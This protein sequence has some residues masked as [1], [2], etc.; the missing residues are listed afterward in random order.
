MAFEDIVVVPEEDY[1]PVVLED[2]Q[3]RYKDS[4]YEIVSKVAYLIGIPLKVFERDQ[5]EFGSLKMEYYL[6]LDQDKNC[7]IIRNLCLIRSAMEKYYKHINDQ[8]RY[9]FKSILSIDAIPQDAI[10]QLGEDGINFIKGSSKFLADHIIE[11]NKLISD[12]INNCKHV[13]PLW[14]NWDYIK[15]L[16]VMPN[17]HTSKGVKQEAEKYYTYKNLY[18]FQTYINWT[19][20]EIGNILLNDK[21]FVLMLYHMHHEEFTDFSKVSSA[22]AFVKDRIYEFLDSSEKI[23]FAVDC[24]NTNPYRLIAT[25]RDLD[26]KYTSKISS[27]ILFDDVHTASVW[28]LMDKFVNIPVEHMLIERVKGDKSLVDIAL[29]SRVTKEHYRNDVDSFVIVSSDSD[30]WA[31]I[32][33]LETANFLVMIESSHCGPDLKNALNSKDIFYCYLD[34]FYTGNTEDV[35]EYALFNEMKEY[36]KK[37]VQLNVHDMFEHALTQTRVDITESEQKQFFNKHIRSLQLYIDDDGNLQ[38]KFKA[39]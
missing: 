7:R 20:K 10:K 19:P 32:K 18:P 25:L 28:R 34:D 24:E 33:E 21:K 39:R 22:G 3:L 11:I 38:V 27:V 8:M 29:T 17:G 14:L 12:R 37:R 5:N 2:E 23:V 1:L 6:E 30:Y 35:K 16:L 36:I 4:T 15:S 26:E 31:L 9:E 13:L